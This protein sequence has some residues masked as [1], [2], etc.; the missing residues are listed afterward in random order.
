M[1]LFFTS[2]CSV[3]GSYLTLKEHHAMAKP[4]R[5]QTAYVTPNAI[6]T[7][8]SLVTKRLNAGSEEQQPIHHGELKRRNCCYFEKP[9]S[10]AIIV[11]ADS[12]FPVSRGIIFRHCKV[13]AGC[14]LGG[15]E[16]MLQAT[17]W[18]QM[19]SGNRKPEGVPEAEPQK[20]LNE[21]CAL[22]ASGSAL[23]RLLTPSPSF[24]RT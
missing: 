20:D 23:C 4:P 3:A 9:T 14:F 21:V 10:M 2:P 19:P 1:Y 13:L 8:M 7:T 24:H 18:L 15:R 6:S 17:F 12:I 5:R 16:E 11:L 22:V